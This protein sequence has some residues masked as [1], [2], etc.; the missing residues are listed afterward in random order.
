MSHDALLQ[1]E[2]RYQALAAGQAMAYA[3]LHTVRL[4]LVIHR[5][6]I[7][8]VDLYRRPRNDLT[9]DMYSFRPLAKMSLWFAPG[10]FKSVL[11]GD[12]DAL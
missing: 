4:S 5:C 12:G 3:K 8:I 7:C 1:Y 10:I 2:L 11:S 6:K 9:A